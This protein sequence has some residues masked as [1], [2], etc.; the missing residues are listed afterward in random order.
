VTNDPQA[1]DLFMLFTKAAA[2]TRKI[3]LGVI[4]IS[5]FEMHPLKAVEFARTSPAG[6][7]SGA[8]QGN[9]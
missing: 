7:S 8:I 4:A 5:P 1:R 6:R 2:V 9:R 3:R